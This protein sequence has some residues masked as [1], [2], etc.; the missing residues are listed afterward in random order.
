MEN[1]LSAKVKVFSQNPQ[2]RCHV[3]GSPNI[4]AICH[5]CYRPM[6]NRHGPVRPLLNWLTENR[7]FN[8]L[9]M[10]K[11]P[12][13]NKEG[14]HCIDHV[15]RSPN[16]RLIMVLPGVLALFIGFWMVFWAGRLMADC[17]TRWPVTPEL[18]SGLAEVLRDP[19]IYD[20]LETG[21]CY[22]PEFTDN[23][24][25]LAQALLVFVFGM[26]TTITGL[27]LNR[28]R[29]AADFAQWIPTLPLGP[30]SEQ[31]YVT[32]TLSGDILIDEQGTEKIT[33]QNV[34]GGVVNPN[35]RFTPSD[36][37]RITEYRSKYKYNEQE[38]IPFNA[39]FLVFTGKSHIHLNSSTGNKNHILLN[40]QIHD[41]P[42]LVH[43][44]GG[45]KA[46]YEQ[47]HEYTIQFDQ[48]PAQE[49]AWGEI[50]L[51]LIPLLE[52]TGNTRKLKLQIQYNANDFSSLR[53]FE[54]NQ[55]PENEINV[56]NVT[57]IEVA[58]VWVDM[59]TFGRP[60]S[61]GI[62]TEN[63]ERGAYQVEWRSLW[64][65]PREGINNLSLPA[66]QF[67]QP[68][69][70]GTR[71]QGYIQIRIPALR[72]GLE[73]VQYFSALGLPVFEKNNPSKL[74]KSQGVTILKI[75]FN[76][77]LSRL[78]L[79]KWETLNLRLPLLDTKQTKHDLQPYYNIVPDPYVMRYFLKALEGGS[80]APAQHISFRQI[81][82]DPPRLSEQQSGYNR[83]H[84]DISGRFYQETLPVDFHLVVS[85][86]G[87]GNHGNT[88]IEISVTGQVDTHDPE[89]QTILKDTLS[90]LRDL[91]E[92]AIQEIDATKEGL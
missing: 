23:I 27:Y 35:F 10:G 24:W 60:Q 25:R 83:W 9:N 46:S 41:H 52:E 36:R 76:V 67:E 28:E 54:D 44:K 57:M 43:G 13:T 14:A 33:L 12:L 1:P 87:K 53:T 39:G 63:I 81:L 17:V 37:Q 49:S 90:K 86:E 20:G 84:W 89:S 32:E 77:A 21:L 92:N 29:T 45:R 71:L 66:I 61:N 15:H 22:R 38:N 31:I 2:L 51:R 5:H 4:A 7:E 40:S 75:H 42:Y 72:S 78:P 34:P 11:W 70:P 68:I 26:G 48:I 79:S 69:Q 80:S 16:Y 55:I 30:I 3:C 6:C 58:K 18:N 88:Q 50:P 82:Q 19:S 91:V 85:G 59:G 56:E 62:V 73:G 64:A 8:L 74:F 47:I 65:I